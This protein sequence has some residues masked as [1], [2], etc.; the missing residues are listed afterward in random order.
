MNTISLVK[1]DNIALNT[2]IK[3]LMSVIIGH[4]CDFLD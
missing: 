3:R 2:G 1:L 4:K